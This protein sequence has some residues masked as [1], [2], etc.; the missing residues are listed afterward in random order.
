MDIHIQKPYERQD[1]NFRLQIGYHENSLDSNSLEYSFWERGGESY[2]SIKLNGRPFTLRIW[3]ESSRK[4]VDL[5]TF[6]VGEMYYDAQKA[7]LDSVSLRTIGFSSESEFLLSI[8]KILTDGNKGE[9]D[10]TKIRNLRMYKTYGGEYT[11][12]PNLLQKV[13]IQTEA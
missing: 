10:F 2:L 1:T 9:I 8:R 6:S 12:S 5:D 3:V 7:I 4:G 11:V 13:E